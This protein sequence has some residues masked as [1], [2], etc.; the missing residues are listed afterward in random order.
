MF[1]VTV[2]ESQMSLGVFIFIFSAVVLLPFQLFLCFK[3][4]K[5]IL[6]LLPVTALFVLASAFIIS[7]F[8]A[9]GWDAIG[10][11]LLALFTGFMIIACGIGWGIW[12][13]YRVIK[14]SSR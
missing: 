5:L 7:S 9:S 6:R 4:K 2:G 14:K 12:A 1:D 8:T 3:V 10:Y 13:I 11:I